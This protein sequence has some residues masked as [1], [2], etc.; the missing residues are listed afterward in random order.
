MGACLPSTANAGPVFPGATIRVDTSVDSFDVVGECSLR[1][2]VYA[3]DKDVATGGCPGGKPEYVYMTNGYPSSGY[4]T[5]PYNYDTIYVPRGTY[6]LTLGG[7][8]EDNGR[9]GDLDV[10]GSSGLNVRPSGKQQKVTID[11]MKS[12]RIFDVDKSAFPAGSY[13]GGMYL[14]KM[15]LT[16]GRSSEGGRDEGGGALRVH[17]AS[18]GGYGLL[19]TDNTSAGD[20][21]AVAGYDSSLDLKSS[22]VSGNRAGRSGGGIYMDDSSPKA[23]RTDYLSGVT[24]AFNRADADGDGIG[25]GGGVAAAR[26]G[27]VS[28]SNSILSNNSV[29]SGAK[30]ASDCWIR[31]PGSHADFTLSTQRLG[32][33][34]CQMNVI[35]ALAAADPK[36][37]PLADNGGQTRTHALPTG[38][39]AIGANRMLSSSNRF[40]C[41]EIDQRGLFRALG[42]CDVGAFQLKTVGAARHETTSLATT[43]GRYLY[44][45]V[46]CP[47]Q[48]EPACRMKLTPRFGKGLKAIDDPDFYTIRSGEQWGFN[49]RIKRRD[50]SR[51]VALTRTS[52][53]IGMELRINARTR[54]GKRMDKPVTI[55]RGYKLVRLVG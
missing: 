38:S 35:R 41:E 50:T 54:S 44:L 5:I 10:S 7:P 14:K 55:F 24:V 19:L 26:Y 30:S 20:G 27:S 8:D 43:D 36:L 40:S 29:D 53:Y 47:K 32:T 6:R 23:S 17:G 16:Q 12:D 34:R 9:T 28:F 37:E 25:D 42:S 4:P 13:P 39:P 11:G 49:Y 48:F 2:A 33:S 3:A 22:T 51:I 45:Q 1:S 46:R 18:A 52:G 31:Q 15:T 21:G